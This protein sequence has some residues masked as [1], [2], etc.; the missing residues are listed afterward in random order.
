MD[1]FRVFR[2][3]SKNSPYKSRKIS[4]LY[5]HLPEIPQ[6]YPYKSKKKGNLYGYFAFLH[7][8][9]LYPG[10]KFSPAV[11]AKTEKC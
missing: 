1:F 5:G 6:K 8:S 3:F 10:E 7:I 9:V 11:A 2:R 4:Y